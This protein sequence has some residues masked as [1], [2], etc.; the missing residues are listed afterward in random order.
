MNQRLSE[1]YKQA[2]GKDWAYDFDTEKAELF[3]SLIIEEC[4]QVAFERAVAR[5]FAFNVSG[6]IRE[7]FGR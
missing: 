3:A 1:L 7:H 2:T 4:A 6:A 5:D